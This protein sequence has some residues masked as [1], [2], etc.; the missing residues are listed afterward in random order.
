VKEY[1]PNWLNDLMTAANSTA[2]LTLLPKPE[3]T[4]TLSNVR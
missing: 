3:T 4:A 2:G 1:N